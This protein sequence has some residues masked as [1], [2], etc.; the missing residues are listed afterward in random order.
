MRLAATFALLAAPWP[1]CA[2]DFCIGGTVVNALT[3]EPLRRAAVTTPQTATLTDAAGAFRFCGLSAGSYYTNGE[4]PGFA[5]TGLAVTVGPSREDVVLRLQPLAVVKGKVLDADGEPLENA[6]IQLLSLSVEDGWRKARVEFA[7]ATDD[8]GEYHI[9]G[10]A[11]GRYLVRAAGCQG[12]ETFTPVY[13]G[14][15]IDLASATPLTVEPGREAS[16]DFS[17][18]LETSYRIQGV[19][20]GLSAHLPARIELL[21]AEGDPSAAPV[22]FNAATGAF[23]INNVAPGSYVLRATEGEGS[24]RRRGEQ[25]VEVGAAD[26]YGVVVTLAA[27]VVVK[28]TV[29]TAGAAGAV[30]AP[31]GCAVD[32]SPAAISLSGEAKLESSTGDDGEFEFSGVLPG[33]YRVRMDCANGYIAAAHAGETDLL[34]HDELLIPPGAAPPVEAVLKT[35]GGRVDV[36]ASEGGGDEAQ[37]WLAVLP[38]SGS[39]LHARFAMIKG[40]RTLTEVAP[41]D[42]QVYCWTGSPADFEYANPAARQAWAGRAVSLHV[43]EHDHQSITVKVAPGE[44]P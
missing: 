42:Y 9:A 41:G 7:V 1:A 2:A 11:P 4:K 28:G 10:L 31:P 23:R 35:D 17:V 12:A 26:V 34:A 40:Q 13:Y 6:L 16:A 8:R 29:L 38:D 27:A 18:A 20:A 43:T 36:T 21:D 24:Q 44:S 33:R 15:A 37:A 3:G 32:L 19:L 39:N 14:G 25:A 30:A 22:E 5:A